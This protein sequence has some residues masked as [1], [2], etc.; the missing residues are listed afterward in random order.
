MSTTPGERWLRI[1]LRSSSVA[2]GLSKAKEDE[3]IMD[4][5][6]TLSDADVKAIARA[7]LDEGEKRVFIGMG[8]GTWRVI[9]FVIITAA[10]SLAIYFSS[11]KR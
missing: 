5:Q 9:Q 3:C 8:K 4:P 6:R 7:V 2:Q 11:A 10:V 1:G